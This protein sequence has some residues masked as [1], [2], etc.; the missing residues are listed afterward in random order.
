MIFIKTKKD[1]E[2]MAEGGRKLAKVMQ[3]IK[4]KV[5]PGISTRELD[6]LAELLIKKEGGIP[7]FKM[8]KGYKF[9]TCMCVNDCVVHGIPA[10]YRLKEGD[11]LGID[12]GMHYKGFHTDM[13]WTVKVQ[14]S[15]P[16]T[17][18]QAEG[19]KVQSDRLDRFLETGRFAL[20]QAIKKARIGN[21]VGDISKAI[22]ETIEGKGHSVVRQLVG[23]GVGK[24]L[25]EEPQI[26]GFSKG[27]IK[28]TPLLQEG[29]TL[30]IEIIYNLGK[31]EVV[32]KNKQDRWTIVTKDKSLSGLFEDTVAITK[33][34]PIVLTQ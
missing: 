23:H 17:R 9:A 1:I 15:K 8:V 20:D 4:K 5:A 22:Q 29:M 27:E 25:H 18:A 14:S 33:S 19:F 26:P 32:Y 2:I 13:A 11:I 6:K 21:Y 10:D 7:S 12:I 34:G 3:A 24:K 16:S 30:A 28:N 31:P